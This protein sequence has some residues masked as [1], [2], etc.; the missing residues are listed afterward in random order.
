MSEWKV[1]K[2]PVGDDYVYQVI[3]IRDTTKVVHSG[4]IEVYGC[5]DTEDE[6]QAIA[7]KLN[8]VEPYCPLGGKS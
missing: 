6:A 5:Y 3:R 1:S 4:N 7:D 2:N 8:E